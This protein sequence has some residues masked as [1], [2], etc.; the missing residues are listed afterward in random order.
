MTNSTY[1]PCKQFSEYVELIKTFAGDKDLLAEMIAHRASCATCI[2]NT[3]AINEWR[4]N[5][6]L[7]S[8]R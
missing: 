1:T 2:E 4:A 5:H 7:Q 6:D 8:S 3:K